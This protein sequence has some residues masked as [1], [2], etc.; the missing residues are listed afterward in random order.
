VPLKIALVLTGGLHPSGTDE[1]IPAILA[2]VERLARIHDLH[3]FA[4][5]HLPSPAR[6]RLA[7]ATVHD[8]GRPEGRWRQWRALAREL[9]EHGP[10]DVI[11]GYWIDPGGLLA[12]ISGRRFGVPS[13]VTC[14]S[15]EFVSL[16][17]ID[18][19]LLRTAR[20]RSVV[21]LSCRLATRL[22]V[23]TGYMAARARDQ[24]YSPITIPIGI[25]VDAG[26][27]T[28]RGERDPKRLLQVA[29]L[30]RVKDQ[31]LLLRALAKVRRHTAAHLDLVGEDTL[32]GELQREAARL[33]LSEAVTFHGFVRHADLGR[34]YRSAAL[35]VQTSRHEAA[36]VSVLEAASY[37]LPVVG[38]RV[39]YISDW[40][41]EAAVAVTPAD[42]DALATAII[43]LLER[44]EERRS[45]AAHAYRRAA[46]HDADW[47]AREL[48][49][50]YASL[51]KDAPE[52]R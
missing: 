23:A 45:I 11:H 14:D 2:L 35:Y 22:H 39:G 27:P 21:R 6:Y 31:G 15:G 18:Y 17:E 9:K 36:G 3:A 51:S 25:P 32:G 47:T 1:I 12:A 33:G 34:F 16:P 48:S 38:T 41:P 7:G 42:H 24:G 26:A 20:G 46:A 40:A 37:G 50:L 30:N 29:S 49:N 4:V 44:P 43:R 10:F 52:K 8:L 19:G 13:V 28:G 5:R